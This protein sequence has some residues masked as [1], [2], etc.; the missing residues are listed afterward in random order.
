MCVTVEAEALWQN[1]KM[2][3][4]GPRCSATLGFP[5]LSAL[6]AWPPPQSPAAMFSTQAP[7]T[8]SCALTKFRSHKRSLHVHALGRRNGWK[9]PHLQP[10]PVQL[11]QTPNLM[12]GSTDCW[13]ARDLSHGEK[14]QAVES[15]VCLGLLLQKQNNPHVYVCLGLF[16]LGG[17]CG[18]LVTMGMGEQEGEWV[19]GWS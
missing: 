4:Q 15:Q 9:S 1:L 2:L 18:R 10:L 13:E 17:A 19:R 12:P 14:Q 7:C 5:V 16:S 6:N 11:E 8:A 3:C